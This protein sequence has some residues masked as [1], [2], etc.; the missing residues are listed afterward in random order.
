MGT[1]LQSAE[2]STRLGPTQLLWQSA[3]LCCVDIPQGHCELFALG[4]HHPR[5]AVLGVSMSCAWSVGWRWVTKGAGRLQEEQASAGWAGL[6][7]GEGGSHGVSRAMAEA[8]C[9]IAA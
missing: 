2:H 1:H 9:L 7:A 6:A 3:M 4:K 8:S 5:P